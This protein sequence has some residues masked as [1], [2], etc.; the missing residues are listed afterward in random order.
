LRKKKKGGDLEKRKKRTAGHFLPF[1]VRAARK[2][3]KKKNPKEKG[4]KRV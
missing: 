1:F 2:V 3:K 4:K